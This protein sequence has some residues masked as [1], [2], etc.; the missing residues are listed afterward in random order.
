MSEL[1]QVKTK[2]GR[3]TRDAAAARDARLLAIATRL[4][5]TRGYDGTSIEALAEAA[6]IGKPTVYARFPGGKAD[7]FAAVYR[8]RVDTLLTPIADEARAIAAPG[9]RG[10]GLEHVLVRIAIAVLTRSLTPESLAFHRMMLAE[11]QR[12]PELGALAH[13]EGWTRMV[14]MLAEL[15]RALGRD[16]PDEELR[17][18]SEL[19]L[20]L[21]VGKV[22]SARMLGWPELAPDMIEQRAR[23]CAAIFLRGAARGGEAPLA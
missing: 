11:A 3:P 9:P 23:R 19:F 8:R 20:S 17:E 13:R 21:V 1:T 14:G 15:M 10:A 2:A 6:G 22:Q 7:L 4:F 5:E 18:D 16:L 12:F